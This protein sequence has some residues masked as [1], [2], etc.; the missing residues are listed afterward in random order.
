M[1]RPYPA[2]RFALV[3]AL[4]FCLGTSAS[5]PCRA[6]AAAATE[7]PVPGSVVKSIALDASVEERILAL[8]P[9]HISDQDVRSTLA[10]GPT[11]R[12]MLFHG[13]VFPVHLLMESFS[14]FLTGMGYPE[15]RIRDAGDGRLSLSPYESSD[16]QAG[17]IAW[18]YEREGVRPILVGHSQGGIQVVKILHELAGAFRDALHVFNPL[19]EEF[20][21]RTTIVDPLTGRERPAVGV[22]V[23]SASAVGTGGWALV[24][25][26]HWMVLSRVRSIPDTVDEFTG[27]RIGIDFFAWDAP[28]LEGVKTFHADGKANVRNVTLPAEYS[29][30][31]VP[32][33]AQLAEDPAVRDWINAFDPNN[34]ASTAPLP[35]HGVS[36]IMW[37]ADVWHGIKRHW[38]LEAQRFV[39][40]RRALAVAN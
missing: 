40:A 12:I 19:T 5:G 6:A 32:G 39:R 26:I 14:R 11:P 22:S 20:E 2:S 33:T 23:A 4:G 28:G 1:N 31:F 8:D 16:R 38:T 29:H 3:A 21:E 34:P 17:M 10:A 9:E 35:E 13:G 25:P 7:R 27:Y 24:L 18:Y 15:E 30:V 36:N 37:A